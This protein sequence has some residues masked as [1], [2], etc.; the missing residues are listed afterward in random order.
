[1]FYTCQERTRESLER[2]IHDKMYI[3]NL[4]REEASKSVFLTYNQLLFS[5]VNMENLAVAGYVATATGREVK[6]CDGHIFNNGK[7]SGNT[8]NV[9][10]V[11]HKNSIITT[12]IMTAICHTNSL[13]T[14]RLASD[15]PMKIISPNLM[16]EI[17]RAANPTQNHPWVGKPTLEHMLPPDTDGIPTSFVTFACS[18][19]TRT[20]TGICTYSLPQQNSSLSC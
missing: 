8:K 19:A 10:L 18:E 7:L 6:F 14:M 20:I 15:T 5:M 1:M 11:S 17:D 9:S 2:E 4:S 16:A 12:M 13:N 3:W